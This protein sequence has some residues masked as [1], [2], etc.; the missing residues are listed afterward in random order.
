MKTR[1][2]SGLF[3]IALTFSGCSNQTS[4]TGPSVAPGTNYTYME[5]SFGEPTARLLISG[6]SCEQMCGSR[7]KSAVAA[8]S[9]VEDIQLSFDGD[10]TVDTLTVS[11]D[12]LKV[13]AEDMVHAIHALQGSSTYHV[14]Q[15][16]LSKE[17]KT[18]FIYDD[19]SSNRNQRDRNKVTAERFSI[20]NIFDALK[21]VSS[22]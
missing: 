20:P 5:E 15:V 9:G 18:S 4:Q 2:T 7:V 16:W 11:F 19:S 14:D 6:M 8:L 22:I 21:R 3:L 17:A 10:V 1:L 13:H 12:P